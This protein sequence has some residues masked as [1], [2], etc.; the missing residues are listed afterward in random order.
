MS[1][2]TPHS[3]VTWNFIHEIM[4]FHVTGE[5]WARC[6]I[7]RWKLHTQ[8]SPVIMQFFG[9]KASCIRFVPILVVFREWIYVYENVTS[10][11]SQLWA[12]GV[13]LYSC[14]WAHLVGLIKILRSTSK[15]MK[16][17]ANLNQL[18][19]KT[20]FSFY[21]LVCVHSTVIMMK[22]CHR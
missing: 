6:G 7:F 1:H 22:W 13:I 12:T 8:K 3:P 17:P 21:S 16:S 15:I 18:E 2:L 10:G 14:N 19:K 5:W 20:P 4:R 11:P 9:C